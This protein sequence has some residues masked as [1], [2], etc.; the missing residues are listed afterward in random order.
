MLFAPSDLVNLYFVGRPKGSMTYEFPN[1][2]V[3]D[4]ASLDRRSILFGSS[5]N[6]DDPD[7]K[8]HPLYKLAHPLRVVLSP[9]QCLYLP[10]YW[11][12]EVQ[13]VPD[14]DQNPSSSTK[15][16]IALNFWFANATLPIDD[17]KVLMGQ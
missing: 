3:R 12:H 8:A 2:F 14:F 1:T 17:A 11:G 15:L 16:N 9:G 13:S 5:V 4:K 7:Y 10:A 6:I